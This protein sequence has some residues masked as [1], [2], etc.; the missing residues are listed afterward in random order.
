MNSSALAQIAKLACP[1]Q[2]IGDSHNYFQIEREHLLSLQRLVRILKLCYNHSR[3]AGH[4]T[5]K[6]L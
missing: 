3:K 1:R 5:Y 6:L 4:L 2:V